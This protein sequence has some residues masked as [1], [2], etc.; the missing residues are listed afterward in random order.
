MDL[1]LSDDQRLL[2]DTARRLLRDRCTTDA[3]RD[4][5]EKGPGYS[6]ELWRTVSDSRMGGDHSVRGPWRSRSKPA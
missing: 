3:V 2:A 4:A 6:A 1:T 5:E